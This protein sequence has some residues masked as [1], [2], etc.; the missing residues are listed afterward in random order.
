MHVPRLSH[1][2]WR[3][4][5]LALVISSPTA[6]QTGGT[7]AGRITDRTTGAPLA[8]SRVVVVGT[9]LET[10]TNERGEYRLLNLRPGRVQLSAMRI[11]YRASSD[12][13]QVAAG[14]SVTKDFTLAAT[15]TT[16]SDVV[17]TGTVGNQERKAQSAVVASISATDI[18]A[19]APINTV[20]DLLQSRVA[21]VSVNAASGQAGASR[22]IR[23]RGPASISLANRPIVFIDGV[24]VVETSSNLGTGGQITDRLNDLNPDDIESI[25]VVK[26]PAAAT[27]F[28]ADASTGVIQIITK[29]GRV[30]SNSF[31]QTLRSE[32]GNVDRNFTPPSNYGA[33]TA[34]L[35]AASSTNPLCR[36]QAVGTLVSDNPLMRSEAFRTG[37]DLLLGWS[38]RGG[39]QNYGYFLSVGAD[40]NLGVLP[41]NEFKRYSVRTNF[42]FIPTPALTIEA[43]IQ[44][45]QST[46]IVPDNDNNIYGYLGGALLGSP[47]TRRDDGQPGQ[48]GWFGFARQVPAISAIDNDVTTRRNILTSSG[49]WLPAAWLKNRLTLGADLV[50]DEATRYF[51]R[52][53]V[54]Q[55]AGLLNT[56]NN[57]QTRLN[58]QRFTADYIADIN[59]RFLSEDKLAV[60][61]SVGAQAIVTRTDSLAATGQGFTTNSSN[62]IGSASTTTSNQQFNETRQVGALGQL[63]LGW[64]DRLFLQL[65]ARYDDFSAFGTE[66]DPIFLPKVGA[67]WVVSDES[68]FEPLASTFGSFRLRAA[69]G[70]T[71]RAPLPGAALTTLT[72][73]PNAVVNGQSIIS[74][75]GAVPLSPGNAK[76]RPEKGT[77]FEAGVDIT[78]LRDRVQL[79]VGF[80]DK[81]S[82]DVLLQRPLPP[83]QGFLANP[84]VNI[85][86]VRNSGWEVSVN[87]ALFR[88]KNFDW[89]SRLAMNTLNSRI[90]SLGEVA[91]FNTLN[92][93]TTGFQ[94]GAFVSKR[95]K[96]INEQTGVVTVADTFEVVGNL[97]PTLEAGLTNTVTLF[98]NLRLVAL[99]DTKQDFTVFNN[100]DFFRETQVVRSNNRLDPTRLSAL[101][102]LRRYGNPNAGQA[103]FV[104]LNGQAT[105]VNETRDAYLQPGDFIRLREVSATYTLPRS[106]ITRW[107]PVN[108][109]SV[110]IAFQN[111]GLWSDYEGF[112]PE[113]VS[114][115]NND[116]NRTDF[117]TLP[118]PRRA[119]LR[120][121]LSF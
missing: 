102:R 78:M 107:G 65:G 4:F 56:G 53:A 28:G 27:L 63:Q 89:E 112:D 21:G 40:R 82:R 38:G 15:L 90:A 58:A 110:G 108:A 77:E 46:S 111:L 119:I 52:N 61:L 79:E 49:T 68:W 20:N 105:T 36:G 55:Y 48:D 19:G 97:W 31:Q 34:A 3:A 118:N 120:L 80:F 92:R 16:L 113:V 83:S 70:T 93:F 62:V 100:A 17:V 24:R 85:G 5:A 96:S 60:N 47:L 37:S 11:G 29:R 121:N 87:A 103:A 81:R 50:Q 106:V 1:W 88:S 98:R 95:I 69:F 51:P 44:T 71:G 9:T 42:N 10:I 66:T 35:V 54:G 14:Q 73:A 26:G 12:T 72:A 76:L 86:E 117:F 25:E 57:T 39:G 33:C 43:G 7:I 59:R 8:D 6:A 45:L 41:N 91:P 32:Y 74:E 18:K 99:V 104:Q 22:S 101:E 30:G 13:L 94:P 2:S 109:A 67:S 75:P 64:R 114:A 23:V 115:A 84:F 116:F